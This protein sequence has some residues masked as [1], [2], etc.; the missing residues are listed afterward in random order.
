MHYLIHPVAS[1]T[2]D[3]LEDILSSQNHYRPCLSQ[4]S[5]S[6]TR[7]ILELPPVLK[8]LPSGVT[9]G[10]RFLTSP[11]KSPVA[12]TEIFAYNYATFLLPCW[13][14]VTPLQSRQIVMDNEEISCMHSQQSNAY[15]HG[16]YSKFTNEGRA[17]T[18]ALLAHIH[19]QQLDINPRLQ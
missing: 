13:R 14:C 2:L 18:G 16:Q 5:S 7:A 3:P 9:H 1:I 19:H 4:P 15:N 6:A 8:T 12:T 10:P 17:V 11:H